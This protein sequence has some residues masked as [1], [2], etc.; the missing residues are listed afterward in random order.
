MGSLLPASGGE[1]EASPLLTA[2]YERRRGEK[3]LQGRES[4]D[5]DHD[6]K[7]RKDDSITYF[8]SLPLFNMLSVVVLLFVS[9][10]INDRREMHADKLR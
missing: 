10:D 6:D 9:Y 4:D 1:G 3:A 2:D 5:W 8:S 7:V